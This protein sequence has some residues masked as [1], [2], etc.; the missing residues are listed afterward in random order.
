[1]YPDYIYKKKATGEGGGGGGDINF[2]VQVY[3]EASV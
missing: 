2:L 1:M 3:E